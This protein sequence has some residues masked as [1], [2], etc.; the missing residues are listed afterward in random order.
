MDGEY[1]PMKLLPKISCR[2]HFEPNV[3]ERLTDN[4]GTA[5]T[6]RSNEISTKKAKP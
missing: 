1:K 5:K 4:P 6:A 3:R 2:T